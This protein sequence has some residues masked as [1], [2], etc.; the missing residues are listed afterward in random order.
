MT[1][2]ES[3]RQLREEFANSV[4][5]GLI[6]ALER[7]H[8]ELIA[9]LEQLDLWRWRDVADELPPLVLHCDTEDG[10]G[11]VTSRDCLVEA[12]DTIIVAFLSSHSSEGAKTCWVWRDHNKVLSDGV[13]T[14]WRPLGP[15]P[16]DQ[17]LNEKIENQ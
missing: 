11:C 1:L 3:V 6:A 16:A 15:T 14:K 17:L 2:F 8:A 13:V 4:R 10:W 9:A 5:P 7:R 12:F